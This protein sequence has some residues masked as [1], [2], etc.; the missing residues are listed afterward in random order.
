MV[1]TGR[2]RKPFASQG[3]RG[4]ESH[5]HRH[6]QNLFLKT[7]FMEEYLSVLIVD[8][9]IKDKGILTNAGLVLGLTAGR[10][11]PE[12][13]FGPEAI[14]GEGPPHKYLTKIGHFVRKAGQSKIRDLRVKFLE[15]PDTKVIDYTEDAAPANYEEY[16]RN[17][18]AHR[19][20]QI[21]Y[22]ALYVYGP[23]D[24]VLPLTKN[25]SRLS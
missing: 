21:V 3:A 6:R 13:T 25:L 24:I 2:S 22:R 23:K 5:L 4:F 19:L 7:D 10:E 12:E 11:L 15:D 18:A 20:E 8:Q 9:S 14:D 17:L 16:T 1:I